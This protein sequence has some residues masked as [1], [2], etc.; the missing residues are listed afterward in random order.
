MFGTA[1][2][3]TERRR[4][5]QKLRQSEERYRELVENAHDLI[6][7]HDLKGNYTSTNQAGEQ[8]TGYTLEES[9]KLN[10]TQTVAPEYLDKAEDMLRRKLAGETVTAYELV[11]IAKDGRRVP[12]EVNTRLVL[13]D[14]VPVGVQGIARDITERKR[15]EE[16]QARRAAHALFRADV[17]AA[18]AMS[19]APLADNARVMRNSNGR[20]SRGGLCPY[21][22]A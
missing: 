11:I 13:H 9:L 1:Q 15:V 4:I 18:L 3:V 8:I 2:D 5:E 10:L 22:D 16:I 6:Y 7:E 21:L 17:S 12:V 14:G 19:S 20:T